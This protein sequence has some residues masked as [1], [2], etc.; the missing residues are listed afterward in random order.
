MRGVVLGFETLGR[1][2][3]EPT[4]GSEGILYQ[5]EDILGQKER[6]PARGLAGALDEFRGRYRS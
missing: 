4:A 6:L 2:Q 3:A 5:I 1:W